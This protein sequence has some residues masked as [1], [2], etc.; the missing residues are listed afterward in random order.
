MPRSLA[1]KRAAHALDCVKKLAEDN[2]YGNYVSYVKSLPAA[3]LMSGLGQALAMEKAGGS[4][5]EGHKLLYRH[6]NA[7][8]CNE[9]IDGV[10]ASGWTNSPYAN[11]SDVLEAIVSQDEADYIRAQAEA[12]EYLEWL[13]KFAVALLKEKEGAE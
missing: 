1:Q 3:I 11:R 13:K 12:L 8:L 5:D 10:E 9:A 7:W 6:M 2:D 4:K